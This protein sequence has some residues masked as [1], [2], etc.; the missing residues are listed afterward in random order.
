MR[1]RGVATTHGRQVLVAAAAVALGASLLPLTPLAG[2]VP[3][4]DAAP[5]AAQGTVTIEVTDRETGAPVENFRYLINE[6]IAN[7]EPSITPPDSYSPIEA[8]GTHV[9]GEGPE[10]VDLPDGRYLLTVDGGAFPESLAGEFPPAEYKLSGEH[11]EVVGGAVTVPVALVPNPLPTSTLRVRVF[12]DNNLVNGEDDIPLEAGLEGFAVHISDPVGE[13]VVDFFGN[14]I[15]TQYDGDP[16]GAF[17]PGNPIPG[18]GGACHSD[19]EGHAVI[20]N[21]PPGKY[22]VEVIPPDGLGWRQTTTIEGT[23]AIDAWLEEGADGF[24]TEEGFLQDVVWFGFVRDCAFG[25]PADDC[26]TN[27]AAGTGSVS[28]TVRTIG[29]DTEGPIFELGDTV[30]SALL[31]LNNIGGDDEQVWAGHG[32]PDGTFTIPNVPEGLYQLVVWDA[33]LDYIIQFRTVRVAD[34]QAVALGDVG[35][36]RWFGTIEGYSYIDSGR[37]RD[38]TV[39]SASNSPLPPEFTAPP[40]NQPAQGNQ[41]RDCYDPDGTV[42]FTINPRNAAT[43][44]PG[45]P[46]QDLD[47]RQKD[48][49]LQYATFADS[50]G[51]YAFPEYFEWEHFLTWEVGY[52]RFRQEGTAGYATDFGGE[53]VGYPYAPAHRT[54]PGLAALLSPQMTAAG[55]TTWIDTGK[56]PHRPGEN[57]GI[58]GVVYYAVTRNEFNPRLA[59]AEDYEPGVPGVEVNLYEAALDG[60]GNPVVEPDGSLARGALVESVTTDDWSENLP[61]PCDPPDL[62]GVE[63]PPEDPCLELPRTFNQM[64]SGVFDGGYAFEGMPVGQY[65]VEV[66]AP[67]GYQVI[68][69]EHQNTDQGDDFVPQIPPPPCS[70]PLH[71]VEDP[72]NPADGQQTPLCTSRLVEVVNG[73]NPAADLHCAGA[74]AAVTIDQVCAAASR[75]YRRGYKPSSAARRIAAR[76]LFTPSFA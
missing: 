66:V 33:F 27:D 15:C 47:V 29:L 59:L 17:P 18:T 8:T 63:I 20:P 19:A 39:I 50:N 24:S 22:E 40:P 16:A 61:G 43:C 58:T 64:D 49:S 11:F 36:P 30:G 28:G 56:Q 31:A 44:E 26:P 48:G 23:H 25:D 65:I 12:H 35:V 67:D 21:L 1:A 73:A 74:P 2:T 54:D 6:D 5:A 52:G 34:G 3:G 72:R 38:G 37:A 57:G 51:R 62:H 41:V 68:A 71:L 7:D 9:A 46:G 75:G 4:F 14:P 69:E 76:R 45:L 32:N 53:P 60:S 13:V 70:G 10:A 55:T 42:P